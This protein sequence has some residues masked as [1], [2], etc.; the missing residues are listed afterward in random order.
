MRLCNIVL[1]FGAVFRL[2]YLSVRPSVKIWVQDPPKT[3]FEK[4]K[5]RL[6]LERVRYGIYACI[7]MLMFILWNKFYQMMKNLLVPEVR[8]DLLVDIFVQN[9]LS[10]ST[11]MKSVSSITLWV[12]QQKW[13]FSKNQSF[14]CSLTKIGTSGPLLET[15]SIT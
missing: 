7:R 9:V 3:F 11:S 8:T 10:D 4:K 1:F 2:A 14:F 15:V 5:T 12:D 13:L 6:E